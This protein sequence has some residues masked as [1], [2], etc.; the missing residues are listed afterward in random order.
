MVQQMSTHLGASRTIQLR[1]WLIQSQRLTAVI[2]SNSAPSTSAAPAAAPSDASAPQVAPE[3]AADTAAAAL[4][5][6]TALDEELSKQAFVAEAM[7]AM[8]APAMRRAADAVALLAEEEGDDDEDC[9]VELG[10]AS[11]LQEAYGDG[12]MLLLQHLTASRQPSVQAWLQL[13]TEAERANEVAAT[14]TAWTNLASLEEDFL[15]INH[16]HLSVIG[17]NV[18]AVTT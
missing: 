2:S 18:H 4:P 9:W 5:S 11:E 1:R 7:E 6:P 16:E 3:A 10:D 17:T 14:T 13:K 8:Q 12:L 15:L